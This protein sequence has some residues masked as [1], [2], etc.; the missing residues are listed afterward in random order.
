MRLRK[1]VC[2]PA[3]ISH[4][5]FE[6][7][8]LRLGSG[9]GEFRD[10]AVVVAAAGNRLVEDRGVGSQAGHRVVGD[11]PLERAVVEHRAGY[12]VNPETLS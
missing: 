1:A 5:E 11:V 3:K 12:V 4:G 2:R 7:D 6:K 9:F 8:L 10:L